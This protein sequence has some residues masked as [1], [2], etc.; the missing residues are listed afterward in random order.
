MDCVR[1]RRGRSLVLLGAFGIY[2][3]AA[4]SYAIAQRAVAGL[5]GLSSSP[6]MAVELVGDVIKP[7]NFN[8][9]RQQDVWYNPIAGETEVALIGD[10][11][12]KTF[13][14]VVHTLV[15]PQTRM[16]GSEW[17]VVTLYSSGTDVGENK[18]WRF[19]A[20]AFNRE[21][22]ITVDGISL[23]IAHPGVCDSW[24]GIFVASTKRRTSSTDARLAFAVLTRE[25][26]AA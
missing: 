4:G 23:V 17:L 9:Q 12:S 6:G 15:R 10:A 24:P 7:F 8:E 1:G 18:I 5:I 19:P 2:S 13:K 25:R 20:D 26:K 11:D 21:V 3:L 16:N 22:R 14:I